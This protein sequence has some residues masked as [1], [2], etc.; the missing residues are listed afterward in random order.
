MLIAYAVML[1][2]ALSGLENKYNYEIV[3]HSGATHC[4]NLVE[5]HKPPTNRAERLAVIT[6][7]IDHASSCASGDNTLAAS[8]RA[9]KHVFQQEADDYFVFVI[10]D[11]KCGVHVSL[12][13]WTYSKP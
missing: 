1:M 9:V 13:L 7:M 4:M 3:G 2:E 5:M 12:V 11:G 8:V 6:T 10:S